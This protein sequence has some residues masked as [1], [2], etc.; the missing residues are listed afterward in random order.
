MIFTEEGKK[1]Y[2]YIV[3]DTKEKCE[4]TIKGLK[5]IDSETYSN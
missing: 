2:P 4:N 5:E 3:Y 1:A